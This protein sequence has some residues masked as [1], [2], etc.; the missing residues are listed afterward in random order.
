MKDTEC[1][2]TMGKF[3]NASRSQDAPQD[4]PQDAPP[5]ED[6]ANTEDTEQ[7]VEEQAD[8]DSDSEDGGSTTT[9]DKLEGD[10]FYCPDGI[11]VYEWCPSGGASEGLIFYHR[12]DSG[13]SKGIV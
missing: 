3:E 7:L 1:D 5:T 12:Y 6:E 11:T 13:W 8:A 4:T 2:A 10:F 9:D